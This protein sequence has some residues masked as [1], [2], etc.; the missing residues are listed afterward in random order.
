M[1]FHQ[2]GEVEKKGNHLV[3]G[4]YVGNIKFSSHSIAEENSSKKGGRPKTEWEDHIEEI[5]HPLPP[6]SYPGVP[7][8]KDGQEHCETL[9]LYLVLT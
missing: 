1:H 3:Y 8:L 6:I 4:D 9:I 7:N 5:E 2:G